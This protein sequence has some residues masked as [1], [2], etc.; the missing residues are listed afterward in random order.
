MVVRGRGPRA[1]C[2]ATLGR[3]GGEGC[4]DA[5]GG[6]AGDEPAS[7]EAAR[8]RRREQRYLASRDAQSS[9]YGIGLES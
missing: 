2:A 1:R 6:E 3:R 9:F 4:A 5:I 8:R 7:R